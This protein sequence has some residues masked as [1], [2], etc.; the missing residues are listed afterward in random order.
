VRFDCRGTVL[1]LSF[2]ICNTAAEAAGI[3]HCLSGALP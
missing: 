3:A 2:H 1:R